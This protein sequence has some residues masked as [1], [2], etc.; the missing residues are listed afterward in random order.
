MDHDT[1]SDQRVCSE[2]E[3]WLR[4]SRGSSMAGNYVSHVGMSFSI[5]HHGEADDKSYRG[6]AE[7]LV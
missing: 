1:I 2:E 6:G 7:H 3:S 4:A 5:V